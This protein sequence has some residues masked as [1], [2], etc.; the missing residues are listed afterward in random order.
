MKA[1]TCKNYDINIS[2]KENSAKV[3]FGWEMTDIPWQED[4]I[5]K[6]TT[7]RGISGNQFKNDHRANS[8]W[9]ATHFI[10]L[11]FDGGQYTLD[12]LKD[13]QHKWQ[14]DSYVFSSQNHQKEKVKASGESIPPCDR[15]RA[16]IPLKTPITEE[17]DRTAVESAWIVRYPHDGFDRSFMQQARYFAHGTDEVCSFIDERGPLDWTELPGLYDQYKKKP[18]RGRPSK[19]PDIPYTFKLEDAVKDGSENEIV[20]NDIEPDTPIYCPVCGGADYRSNSGHNAVWMFNDKTELPFIYCSSCDSRGLGAGGKGVYNLNRDEAHKIQSEKENAIVF[21]DTI[22]SRYYGGCVENGMRDFVVRPITTIDLVHQFCKYNKLQIPDIFPRARFELKFNR[23]ETFSYDEGFVNK[24]V[25]TEYLR[26][27][28]PEG[29]IA[30]LPEYIG[31]VI[32]HVLA[33]DEEIKK[34]FYNDMAWFIQNRQKMITSYLFQGVEG[35][36]KGFLFTHV[37]Q[38]IFGQ[39]YCSQ[40]D[41]DAFGNQ[42]NSF[43]QDNVLVLVN[44]VSGNFSTSD[45]K[46]LSTIEKMKIAITDEHI[47][48]EGKNKDRVNGHN[49]CSF[50]FATNRRHGVV[51]SKNDRRFNVAPRQEQKIHDADWWPGFEQLKQLVRE[52]LQE[53]VWYMK[54]YQ[55]DEDQI[56]RVVDNEPKKVLQIM[57]QSHADDFFEAVSSGNSTWLRDNYSWYDTFHEKNREAKLIDGLHGTDYISSGVLR[58]LYNAITEKSLSPVAFGKLAAGYL[59]ESMQMKRGGVKFRGWLIE[60]KRVPDDTDGTR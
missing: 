59:G 12:W 21:V 5:I 53:F 26:K 54:Q 28:V 33:D 42:F 46:N 27:P 15:L 3:A 14:F 22:T 50:L 32:N 55:V 11:D 23:D 9:I 34:Q 48:V 58:E 49:Q 43:L 41:Q 2:K 40:T 1:N 6:L 60:W 39:N 47:Q 56:G 18:K 30:G 8:D 57:S 24:Y 44:E 19:Q 25:A 38:P 10:M 20:L 13:E 45:Q 36:G 51:L 29:H 37:F 17:F 7:L 31:K 16:L 35:T 4:E 52:E